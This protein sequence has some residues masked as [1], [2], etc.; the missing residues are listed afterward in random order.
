MN[1]AS[2]YPLSNSAPRTMFE[3]GTVAI[4]PVTSSTAA[5]IL[6]EAFNRPVASPSYTF[7]TSFDQY[8][9][10]FSGQCDRVHSF[11]YGQLDNLD[12]SDDDQNEEVVDCIARI[13][14]LMGEPASCTA[15]L[16]AGLL[17]ENLS[18]FEPLLLA[19]GAS[20]HR[21][22][23]YLRAHALRG[24]AKDADYRVRKAA[25][26]ALGRMKALPAK[27][28]LEEISSQ[29]DTGEIALLAAAMLR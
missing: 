14:D 1:N 6:N 29:K 20:R 17:K 23:E 27:Q 22:T 4:V 7:V 15:V 24:Y 3:D 18:A 10:I 26:R 11:I 5:T 8:Q 19:I 9:K 12:Q 25:V 21:D 13:I 2:L 28:A 16:E